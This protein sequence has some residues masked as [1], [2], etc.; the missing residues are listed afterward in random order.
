MDVP[1]LPDVTEPLSLSN[2]V[3]LVLSLSLPE[4]EIPTNGS[5][6]QYLGAWSSREE[7]AKLL[8]IKFGSRTE[9]VPISIAHLSFCKPLCAED[10]SLIGFVSFDQADYV[11]G[12]LFCAHIS[13]L[14]DMCPG[15]TRREAKETGVKSH[16]VSRPP[17]LV[18][19]LV[20]KRTDKT[21]H[22]CIRVGLAEGN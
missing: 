6:E 13:T 11:K 7:M 18:Y 9:T 3:A 2:N 10:Q 5:I 17:I 4:A 16:T 22:E 8:P 21:E 20:L 12:T 14:S 15:T 1:D 19:A